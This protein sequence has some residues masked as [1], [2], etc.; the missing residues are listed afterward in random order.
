MAMLKAID[1]L[2]DEAVVTKIDTDAG[3][4][5]EIPNMDDTGSAASVVSQ[6][7]QDVEEDPRALG[8]L[9]F[10]TCPQW[11]SGIIKVSREFYKDSAID[12]LPFFARSFAV[13]FARGIGAANVAT[14][15]SSATLGVIAAGSSSNDGSGATGA[16][17]IGLIDLE[18]L[19]A[20]VDSAYLAS[21]KCFWA[22]SFSTLTKLWGVKDKQGHNILPVQYNAL[23]EP[24]L[25][26]LRVAVCPSMPSIGAG[27][28]PIALGD[29]GR[30]IVRGVKN[31]MRVAR[32]DERWAEYFQVGFEAF[33]RADAGLAVTP[34]SPS[35][36]QYIQN[37]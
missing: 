7:Q 21:P 15:L 6:G 2:F 32:F 8:Q 35:P 10:L 27:N 29:F 23:G 33:L 22:M 28:T 4:P 14:M 20:A 37:S 1:R 24:L 16:N 31:S 34:G 5:A 17:S 25:Y 13:R 18:G 11:R 36:I 30:F 12:L 19:L 9:S 26:G 3:G